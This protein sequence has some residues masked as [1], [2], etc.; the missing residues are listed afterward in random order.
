MM[1]IGR[2]FLAAVPMAL[3]LRGSSNDRRLRPRRWWTA[4][5]A[6]LYAMPFVQYLTRADHA[7]SMSAMLH[8]LMATAIAASALVLIVKLLRR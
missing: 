2:S 3:L 6:T 1:L 5:T 4:L 7:L 8:P